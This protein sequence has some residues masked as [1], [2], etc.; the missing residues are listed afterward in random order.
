MKMK[1]SLPDVIIG[2][3][4]LIFLG[5][6]Y[7]QVPAIPEISKGYPLGLLI[8]ATVMT[9]YLLIR[10][11]LRLKNDEVVESKIPEQVKVIAPYCLLI[12]AY[13]WLLNKLGYIISTVLFMIASLLFLKLKNKVLMI[14]LSVVLTCLLYYVFTNFLVVVLPRGRWFNIAF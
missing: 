6:L 5:T 3:I 4:V 13:I 10:N 8:I 14:V 11:L 12:I 2:V 1:K 9:L 7:A